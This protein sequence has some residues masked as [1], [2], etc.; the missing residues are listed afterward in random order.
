MR[1]TLDNQ[2]SYD[3]AA[4]FRPVKLNRAEA[5]GNFRANLRAWPNALKLPLQY[6]TT[7][8]GLLS[9][10]CVFSCFN[11][12]LLLLPVLC[13]F[14][15]STKAYAFFTRSDAEKLKK[16]KQDL[17]RIYAE[18]SPIEDK[19]EYQRRLKEEIAKVNPFPQSKRDR[20]GL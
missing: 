18:L 7:L 3:I 9:W 5:W 20:H 8:K 16:Y 17:Q 4:M 10:I 6:K 19:D 11:L 1:L 13:C 14:G 2:K 12:S 15:Y